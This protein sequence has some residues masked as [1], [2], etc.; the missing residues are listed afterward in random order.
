MTQHGKCPL[1]H[2]FKWVHYIAWGPVCYMRTKVQMDADYAPPADI[3]GPQ[4]V[5]DVNKH[6]YNWSDVYSVCRYLKVESITYMIR[7][8]AKIRM[9]FYIYMTVLWNT[10]LYPCAW[11]C[12]PILSDLHMFNDLVSSLFEVEQTLP[13]NAMVKQ[14][15]SYESQCQWRMW[16]HVDTVHTPSK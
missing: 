6:D 11:E 3:K 12:H 9:L 15:T 10:C 1:S 16:T 14:N 5:L 2:E 4:N 13:Y 7:I 8:K